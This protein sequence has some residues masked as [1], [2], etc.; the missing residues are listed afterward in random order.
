MTTTVRTTRLK[1]DRLVGGAA[2]QFRRKRDGSKAF[3]YHISILPSQTRQALE[4]QQREKQIKQE[5]LRLKKVAAAKQQPLAPG[6][7]VIRQPKLEIHDVEVL[8]RCPALMES[9]V[10]EL[11]QHQRDIADARCVV[12]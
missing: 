7:A 12:V 9:D 1:L 11:T 5:A 8:R 3:E 10:N 2:E 4:Q 6:V